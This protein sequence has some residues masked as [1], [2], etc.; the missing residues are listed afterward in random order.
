[1]RKTVPK[2][3]ATFLSI[4][5]L[6][7]YSAH[8]V[9][10][11]FEVLFIYRGL[12]KPINSIAPLKFEDVGKTMNVVG[13]LR[14][15]VLPPCYVRLPLLDSRPELCDFATKLSFD[16]AKISDEKIISEFRYIYLNQSGSIEDLP[17]GFYQSANDKKIWSFSGNT[18]VRNRYGFVQESDISRS[19]S[20]PPRVT[21]GQD[22]TSR[23]NSAPPV[24]P[25]ITVSVTE[26]GMD[27]NQTMY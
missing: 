2:L 27:T 9:K 18:Y 17:Q 26:L 8:A 5:I 21:N 6:C 16:S 1:M 12:Q 13:I 3:A 11:S 22:D 15:P 19:R 7:S 23:P 25:H 20:I 10:F 14:D 4:M 24:R